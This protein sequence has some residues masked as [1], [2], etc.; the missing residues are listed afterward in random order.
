MLVL[1]HDTTVFSHII[2]DE[3]VIKILLL[4]AF[5]KLLFI[6]AIPITPQEA[7]YWYYSTHPDLSYFDH[8]PLTAYSILIG[9]NIFGDNSLGVK[10][11]AVIWW[12]LTNI[13]L[14]KTIKKHL[15]YYNIPQETGSIPAIGLILYN[16]TVFGNLYSIT[17]VPDTPLI[18]FWLLTFYSVQEAVRN[19]RKFWWL[20]AGIALGFALLSKYS[21]IIITG[22]VL[23]FLVFDKESRKHLLS[24]YPYLALL[25]ALLIFSPVIIW[26]HLNDWASFRFQFTERAQK[27]KPLQVKY[28]LQLVISQF[29]LLT[30]LVLTLLITTT[31]SWIKNFRSEKSHNL[32]FYISLPV[33]II[34]T[35]V[36]FKSL[37]K[38]NWLLPGYVVLI[39]A[40]SAMKYYLFLRK[41]RIFKAGIVISIIIVALGYLIMIVPN[42]PLGEGNTWSG[43]RSAAL[44]VGKYQEEFGGKDSCFIFGNSYKS[45]SLLK[46][47]LNNSQ[48]TYAENIIGNRAL[49]FDYWGS[50]DSLVGKNAIYVFDDRKEYKNN[51]DEVKRFFV[52]IEKIDE[53]EIKFLDKIRTRKITIYK[54]SDYLGKPI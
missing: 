34:F 28:F 26:N 24:P 35:A 32:V 6:A 54:C 43:W 41:S 27:A 40:V 36:S 5:I 45:A 14:F 19:N 29:F 30:P 4:I 38:M 47:Y 3:S 8:P 39:I 51:L 10:F 50:T 2:N 33:I 37:V 17:M 49:Q 48:D 21:A 18:F 25:L 22:S 23:L 9:T 16:I 15:E 42:V 52:S 13:L 31:A 20:V 44:S 53:I 46:F 7:Y 11:M 1:L 12:L